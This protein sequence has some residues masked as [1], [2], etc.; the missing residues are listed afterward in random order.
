M[1]NYD[2]CC[3]PCRPDDCCRPCDPCRQC[4]PCCDPCG[5]D[6]NGIWLLIL[7]IVI[8]LIFCNDNK[9]GGLFGG[10]F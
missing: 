7:I 2:P 3:D 9:G 1:G 8:Y 4:D 5:N 6:N 10:L